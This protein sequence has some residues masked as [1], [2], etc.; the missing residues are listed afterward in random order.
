MPCGNFGNLCAGLL[1][2]RSGLPVKHFVAACN[3]NAAVMNYF[4]TGEYIPAETVYTISNAM[5][6]GNPSNFIRMLHLFK[7]NPND[8]KKTVTCY[9]FS[10]E[11]NKLAIKELDNLDYC[12]D[13]HGAIGYLGLKSYL[14]Q[15]KT[16]AGFF[17]ETA[18]P[19][20]FNNILENILNKKMSIDDSTARLL[21]LGRYK[22]FMDPDYQNLKDYL[23]SKFK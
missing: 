5:D 9:S 23:L 17:L 3:E 8:L 4:N 20:K 19:I 18:H 10:G 7:S 12:A 21:N 2:W 13:P 16:A 11:E 22:V 1:A 15:N 6:V 14:H